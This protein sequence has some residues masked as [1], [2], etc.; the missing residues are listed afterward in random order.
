[1]DPIRNKQMLSQNKWKLFK[2]LFEEVSDYD[3]SITTF[4]GFCTLVDSKLE[5]SPTWT[6]L[7]KFSPTFSTKP[8]DS[9]ESHVFNR[10]F[11]PSNST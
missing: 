3:S 5:G 7:P 6:I 4:N 11:L 1:M 8:S 2:L 10:K 9:L